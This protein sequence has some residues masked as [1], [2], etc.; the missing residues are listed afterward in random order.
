M[1]PG[2]VAVLRMSPARLDTSGADFPPAGR[3]GA[4]I[5]GGVLAIAT[6]LAYRRTIDVPFL[7]DDLPS[8]VDNPTIRSLQTAWRPPGDSG[9]TVSGR[10]LLN[11]SLALNFAVSGTRVWSYHLGNLILHLLTGCLLH[12]V[13]RRTLL[14]PRL[15][16]RFGPAAGSLALAVAMI[17]TVHP[18]QTESVT[19]VVQ[20]AEILVG[21][22][23]LLTFYCFIRATDAPLR[24][25]W[26]TASVLACL[27]GMAAK[28]VMAS[29]PILL[30]LYDRI[31]L[32][33]SWRAVWQARGRTHLAFAATWLLL[34]FLIDSTGGRGGTVGFDSPVTPANYALTQ[35]YAI[36]TYLRLTVWPSSLVFDYGVP[37]ALTFSEIAPEFALFVVVVAS[38]AVV[39]WRVPAAGY[40]W[41]FFF[42]V[43]APT[44][45]IV[46]VVTQTMAEHRMY[47]ALAGL[48]VFAVVLL[49]V[50]LGRHARWLLAGVAGILLIATWRRN[51]VYR[52][53]LALWEDTA[54]KRP[55]N[56][57]A[58][59]N[60]GMIHYRAGQ[61]AAAAGAYRRVLA[62]DPNMVE[63]AN[64]L[65]N[66]LL[67]LGRLSEAAAY[68][69][70]A[71]ASLA[72]RERAIALTN[73]GNLHL[74]TGRRAAALSCL[75][76]AVHL[77]PD[78]ADARF[79]LANA[80]AQA[81]YPA[82]A[83]PHYEAALQ[84]RPD[85]PELRGN[86]ANAL[87]ETGRAPD[88]IRELLIV[89]RLRPASA[90]ARNNLGVALVLSG[91]PAEA[92][93]HFQ[94]AV[95]L[96]PAFQEA[97]ENLARAERALER[98]P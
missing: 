36:A 71:L 98:S 72:G 90:E 96:D 18:L 45:S 10:P 68:F 69:E 46:P 83:L 34:A 55:D 2:F 5:T 76:E 75:E 59:L 23:Y 14:L 77:A 9:V 31:F 37:Q 50:A 81:G 12:G 48:V 85:D 84:Q 74:Q 42:G 73:L 35:T 52:S 66:S 4:W 3:R 13:V 62:L 26:L 6:L 88:A 82:A 92:R 28:E 60:I 29:A 32:A 47:L 49:H 17:W 11:L 54:A 30:L 27:A 58:H 61:Y 16:P 65:G 97:R 33:G 24:R 64:N 63:A 53:D 87:M 80:L 15:A 79:N 38:A 91:R 43:L 51:E 95:D 19:Y 56:L 7:M 94:Y 22:F 86:F 1:P 57:R 70:R 8:I 44:S 21:F 20:R 78:L 40:C 89:V 25:R 93:P 41:L 67:K 39:F